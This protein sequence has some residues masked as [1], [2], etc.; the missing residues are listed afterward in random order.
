MATEKPPCN[1]Q[2][3]RRTPTCHSECRD[4]GEYAAMLKAK[5]EAIVA[6]KRSCIEWTQG[7]EPYKNRKKM[8]KWG[9]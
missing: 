7:K 6:D 3:E 2:C 8:T 9:R 5:K 1:G 4:Y